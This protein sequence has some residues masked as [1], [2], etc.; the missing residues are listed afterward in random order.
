MREP[1]VVTGMGVV[2]PLGNTVET[3]WEGLLAGRSGVRQVPWADERF[4]T[5]IAALCED[6]TPEGV[7]PRELRRQSRCI[8]FALEAANQAWK[9]AGLDI[10]RENPTRCGVYIGSGIGGIEEICDNTLKLHEQG[11][12]RVSPF[13]FPKGLSNMPSAV[14]AIHLRLQGPSRSVVTA[15]S[16]GAQSIVSA[17]EALWLGRADVMLAGGTEAAVID[18]GLA[19][20]GAIRALS[21]RNDEPERASRPFDADR[22]GFVLGEGAGVLVLET[23]SHARAR[24]AEILAVL[25]GVGETT[26]AYHVVAPRP[27]GSGCAEAMRLALE[28]AGVAPDAVGYVNAHGT[29]TKLNDAAECLAMRSVFGNHEPWVS[30]TKSM[31]GHLMGAAGGVESVACVQSLRTGVLHENKNY[32]KPDP[33]CPARIVAGGPKEVKIDFALSNSLGFGGHNVSLLFARHG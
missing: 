5:R 29:S 19:G 25:A 16:T 6:V 24:N 21:T 20:F 18:L 27:D 26:D 10:S 33:E 13:L 31:I 14:V 32:E 1:V 3:F 23:L 9:Q 28:D 15:C 2:T 4:T 17:A 11:P 8:Q 12:R 22:D 30:S 7:D